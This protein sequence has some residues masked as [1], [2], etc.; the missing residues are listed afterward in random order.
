MQHKLF[1][2][3]SKDGF[4]EYLQDKGLSSEESYAKQDETIIFNSA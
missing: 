2:S 1:N 3:D 4:T